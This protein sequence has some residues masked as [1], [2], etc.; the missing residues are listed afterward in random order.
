MANRINMPK[1]PTNTFLGIKT[2]AIKME[3]YEAK[4]SI[5]D[6]DYQE[7]TMYC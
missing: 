4:Y 1:N 3:L 5:M 6:F 7:K 2:I